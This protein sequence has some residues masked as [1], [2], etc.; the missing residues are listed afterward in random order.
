MKK[1]FKYALIALVLTSTAY[2]CKTSKDSKTNGKSFNVMVDRFADLQ[3]LRY[4]VPGFEELPLKQKLFIYHLSEAA[5]AGRDITY[6]QNYKH[7][8]LYPG[9]H[10]KKFIRTI[11]AIVNHLPSYYLACMLSVFG[12]VMVFITTMLR[13]N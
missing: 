11:K 4:N 7:N 8:L 13:L 1:I 12:L 6:D 3:V 10:S 5:L 9:K 2:A